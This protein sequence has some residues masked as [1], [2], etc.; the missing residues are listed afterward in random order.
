MGQSYALIY[1]VYT[2]LCILKTQTPLPQMG[3]NIVIQC[4]LLFGVQNQKHTFMQIKATSF[5]VVS[6]TK[7]NIVISYLILLYVHFLQNSRW[8]LLTTPPSNLNIK[9]KKWTKIQLKI[10]CKSSFLLRIYGYT[11]YHIKLLFKFILYLYN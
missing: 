7:S 4:Y 8:V 3:R 2:L 6:I 5:T 9:I 1:N 10:H 11:C